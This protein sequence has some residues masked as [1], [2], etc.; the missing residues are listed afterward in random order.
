LE[1]QKQFE[2]EYSNAKT[3]TKKQKPVDIITRA[4]VEKIQKQSSSDVAASLGV[5]SSKINVKNGDDTLL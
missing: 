3:K 1:L 5:D 4:R 2:S